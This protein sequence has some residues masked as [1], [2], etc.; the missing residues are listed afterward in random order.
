MWKAPLILQNL[1]ITNTH[2]LYIASGNTTLADSTV[3]SSTTSGA[4]VVSGGVGIGGALN[5]GGTINTTGLYLNNI[6]VNSTSNEINTLSKPVS[7][8]P[9]QTYPIDDK[10]TV[11]FEKYGPVIQFV[12][13]EKAYEY[14]SIK[15][16]IKLDIE[17]LKNK[18]YTI[19]E[20]IAIKERNLGT[21]NDKAVIIRDGKYGTYVEYDNLK[22]SLKSLDK[23][24][25]E[26]TLED[27]I[28]ILEKT[29]DDNSRDKSI[30]RE[31][32]DNMS[33][34]KGKFG[35]YV[36]YKTEQMKK[37]Q[38]LNIKKF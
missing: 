10:Y 4:L 24:T 13:D 16:D 3:S 36:F 27:V 37:P 33:I 18:E 25:E 7:K 30:L 15:S 31:L 32:N 19:D 23:K 26:I 17:K 11:L 20:L 1:T 14:L 2:A 5:V 34:R 21:Y 22:E 35:A 8:I 28:C 9:K 6:L 29:K 38:F 12:N